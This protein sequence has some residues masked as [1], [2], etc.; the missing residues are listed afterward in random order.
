MVWSCGLLALKL[1]HRRNLEEFEPVIYGSL[2]CCK[3]NLMGH[4]GQNIEGQ[5]LNRHVDSEIPDHKVSERSEDLQEP[6]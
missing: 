2:K 6:Y 5:N 3:P 1:A 4:S